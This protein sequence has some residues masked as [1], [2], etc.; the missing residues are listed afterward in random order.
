MFRISVDTKLKIAIVASVIL[1]CASS[2]IVLYYFAQKAVFDEV[3]TN[4]AVFANSVAVQIDGDMMS[5]IQS[6]RDENGR[7]YN[8]IQSILRRM[9]KSN[10]SVKFIYTMRPGEHSSLWNFVVDAESDP[11]L[12]SH[13]GDTYDASKLPE[14]KNGLSRPS[15]DL[16]LAQDAWGMLMSG[17]APVLDRNGRSVGIVGID[18]SAAE[19]QRKMAFIQSAGLVCILAGVLLSLLISSVLSRALLKPI[20]YLAERLKRAAQGNFQPLL[21]E[22]RNDEIG[23]VTRTFNEMVSTLR[24]KERMLSEMNVDYLTGLNNHRYFQQRLKEEVEEA[25]KRSREVSLLMID[26]DTFKLINDSLGHIAGDEVLLQIAQ[27]LVAGTSKRQILARYG[28]EEFAVI[29]PDTSLEAAVRIGDELRRV[30]SV[31]AFHMTPNAG[32][33]ESYDRE[34]DVNVTISVG[35]A[36]FPR[37]STQHDGLIMAADIALHQAKHLGR[38][39]I[40]SYDSPAEG[41][42]ADPYHIYTFIQDPTRSAM[43]A[44]AAAVD[45]R[46]HYTRNH[47]DSVSRYACCIGEGLGMSDSELELLR[48]A[49]LLHDVGKIGVPDHVLNKPG[50]LNHEEMEIIRTHP[51]VGEA[52]VRKSHNLDTILPGILYHH[53][54]FDGSGYPFG[55]RGEDIPILA[56]IIAVADS[57]DALITDRPYRK[58]L[59]VERAREVLVENMGTQFDPQLVEVFLEAMRVSDEEEMETVA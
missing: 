59:S 7:A 26:I 41:T 35:A 4:L 13:V 48:M 29:L 10:K 11:K 54:H 53:E 45:A 15:A 14:L 23:E 22:S 51:A 28:G 25:R 31:N 40:C 57:F 3:R 32:K 44:L 56:R 33:A 21:D 42:S 8:H 50:Q 24:Q 38:N 20:S 12:I 43:E 55:L 18:I 19:L 27:L 1:I 49:G 47:S 2:E 6:R 39:R 5:S 37:H 52:I 36:V 34:F 16:A 58:A 9:K 17:Y 46:D 30:I